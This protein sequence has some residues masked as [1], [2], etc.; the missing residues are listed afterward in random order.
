M[1]CNVFLRDS[2]AGVGHHTC[3]PSPLLVDTRS[4]PPLGM[5]S[6]AFRKRFRNTCCSLPELP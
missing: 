2:G 5:A 6:F 4:V 1:R 3:T